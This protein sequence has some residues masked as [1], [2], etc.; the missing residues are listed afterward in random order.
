MTSRRMKLPPCMC[1]LACRYWIAKSPCIAKWCDCCGR[2]EQI[3]RELYEEGRI[4]ADQLEYVE[5]LLIEK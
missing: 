1:E 4:P 2:E 3:M 5:W